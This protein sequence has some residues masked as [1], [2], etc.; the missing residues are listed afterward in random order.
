MDQGMVTGFAMV[1]RD[2]DWIHIDVD[3]AAAGPYGGTIGHGYLT[4]SLL[5]YFANQL[6]DL[7][8]PNPRLNYGLNKVRFP[9][10]V[11]VGQR[12]RAHGELLAFPEI[13]SGH[14][15]IARYTIEIENTAKPAC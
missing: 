4:L 15:F 11:R 3:R 14:Q 7:D 9:E 13:P 12:V 5:P 10:P 2:F 8:L 6:V 1:T